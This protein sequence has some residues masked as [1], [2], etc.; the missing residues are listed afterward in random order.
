MDRKQL[1]VQTAIAY[2][3]RDFEIAMRLIAQGRIDTGPIHTATV[4]L[5]DL[6]R[7]LS[8]IA[9][10]QSSEGKTLVDPTR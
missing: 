9:L 8:D 2:Q 5:G 3:R 1:S 6:N 10:G 4:G 7:I